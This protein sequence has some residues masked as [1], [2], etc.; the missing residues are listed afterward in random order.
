MVHVFRLAQLGSPVLLTRRSRD[1]NRVRVPR[2]RRLHGAARWWRN[3]TARVRAME[4]R[5][6]SRLL[7]RT[8]AAE[9]LGLPMSTFQ[10][11]VQPHVP[12][13]P[14]GARPRFT[15][16]DLDAWVDRQKVGRSSGSEAGPTS[17]SPGTT[18]R[19]A[20]PLAP[21]T[22]ARLRQPRR[23]SIPRSSPAG[24]GPS[25]ERPGSSST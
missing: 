7:T 21:K 9:Y 24:E 6:V 18:T 25:S 11:H 16:E 15:K 23:G 8:E 5:A 17:T 12:C 20:L 22:A 19:I 3:R 2:L 4:R 10:E 14:V 13:V 1:E